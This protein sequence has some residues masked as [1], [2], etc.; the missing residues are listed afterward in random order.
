MRLPFA[1]AWLL[2]L[3]IVACRAQETGH[4]VEAGFSSIVITVEYEKRAVVGPA[5]GGRVPGLIRLEDKAYHRLRIADPRII[6]DVEELLADEIVADERAHT[7]EAHG[8][9]LLIDPIGILT[10]SELSYDY[11]E[12]H[13]WAREATVHAQGAVF[14]AET[15]EMRDTE[16]IALHGSATTCDVDPPHYRVGFEKVSIRPGVRAKL[17]R[18]DIS[19]LGWRLVRVPWLTVSLARRTNQLS[20]PS[21]GYNKRTGFRVG[22]RNEFELRPRLGLV[23][24][25]GAF[26][27]SKP[28]RR[29][30]VSYSLLDP[31]GQDVVATPDTE[32]G[33]RFTYSHIDN[34]NVESPEEED[35][36][37]RSRRVVFFFENSSN[38]PVNARIEGDL[39]VS[40]DWEVGLQVN[41]DAGRLFG[42]VSLRTGRTTE[43]PGGITVDRTALQGVVSGGS[44]WV[45]PQIAFRPRI[46]G[47]L[48]RYQ[49]DS[50]YGWWRPVAEA[51]YEPTDRFRLS[52]AYVRTLTGGSAGLRF[53]QPVRERTMQARADAR[54]GKLGISVLTKY[55]LDAEYTFDVEVGIRY[56]LHCVEPQ[57][58]WRENPGE[59]RLGIRIP[60]IDLLDTLTHKRF[61]R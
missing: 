35:R 21:V 46:D 38:L 60:T 15:V 26:E 30:L 20:L 3:A 4:D 58:V 5:G 56:L 32:E 40:K 25:I 59:F 23:T 29:E 12:R 43:S 53:D 36:R 31:R 41:G 45:S 24:E 1:A 18:C 10:A 7:I 51:V 39:I 57:I 11:E 33:E 44:L 28:E 8:H 42:S 27:R 54:L 48:F 14:R 13:G 55:D 34:V 22:W 47:A 19:I 17:Y 16:W 52:L 9:V 6:W 50:L 61:E 37:L 2:A 49:N